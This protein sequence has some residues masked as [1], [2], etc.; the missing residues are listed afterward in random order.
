MV[1]VLV[2]LTM[3]VFIL[4]DLALR[5][6]LKKR[7][8]ARL[9]RERQEALDV[10]LRL[11]YTDEAASL[12][13]VEV[14]EPKARILA[15]DDEPVVLDSFRKILVLEGYSIDTVESAPEAIGLVRKRDYDFVYADLKMPGMDG[16]E[17]TKAVK[18]LRPDI[19]VVIITGYASVESAVETMKHGAMD[20]V[21]KPFT[22][23]ELADFTRKI[24]IRREDRRARTTPLKVRLVEPGAGESDSPRIINVPGGA[25][26]SPEH[27]WATLDLNGEVG[28]GLDDVALK[29]LLDVEEIDLPK[30][31]QR[32]HRGEPLFSVRRKDRR[33]TFSA[34]VGGRISRVNHELAHHLDVLAHHPFASSWIC[35]L[36]PGHLTDDLIRLKVGTDSVSWY[37]SELD[38]FQASF[39]ELRREAV[40]AGDEEEERPEAEL[41]IEARWTAFADCFLSAEQLGRPARFA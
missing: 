3:V 34:P 35:C 29:M 40:A 9:R 28:I 39:A 23:D 2:L 10:G 22:A 13:R 5:L 24:L 36:V 4:V 14:K 11:E 25:F 38:R 1:P 15:V 17:L 20:Y 18:H 32:V 19:D 31:G 6:I 41:D 7:E 26:V 30:H 33:L 16:I 12:K 21:Q 37:E 8:E 27:T